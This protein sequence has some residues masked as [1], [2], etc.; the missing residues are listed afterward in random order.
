ML[1]LAVADSFS[2]LAVGDLL[3]ESESLENF[4]EF[5]AGIGIPTASITS[6]ID[7]LLSRQFASVQ[8]VPSMVPQVLEEF[9]PEEFLIDD[10]L[11]QDIPE[12]KPDK[13][14]KLENTRV[15]QL[16]S[17]PKKVR[18][19]SRSNLQPGYYVSISGKKDTLI[20][21]RLG[22]CFRVYD[23]DYSR[24][25]NL[26][27]VPVVSSLDKTEGGSSETQTSSSSDED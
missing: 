12:V 1:Q 20:L 21:H 5:M 23:I 25:R 11:Q 3:A 27:R 15:Q 22:A 2:N 19:E 26:G 16:G 13:R 7:L 8:R 14:R 10:T 6:T 17:D 18:S 4:R 9:E 24:F